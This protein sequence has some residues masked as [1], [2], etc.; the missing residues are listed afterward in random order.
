MFRIDSYLLKNEILFNHF[1]EKPKKICFWVKGV[2][3]NIPPLKPPATQIH[4]AF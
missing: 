3:K 4:L 1:A 2:K